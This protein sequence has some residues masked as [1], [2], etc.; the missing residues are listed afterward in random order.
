M[1]SVFVSYRRADSSD[2]TG[3]I[4]DHLKAEFGEEQLFKDVEAIPLGHDFRIVI[5]Q[6]VGQCKVLIAI[7]GNDWLNAA[8]ATGKR[9]ID[10]PNDYV[11]FEI[12]TALERGIP[13]I[14]VLV[15]GASIPAET[16]LPPALHQL[17]FRNAVPVRVDPDFHHDINRLLTELNRQVGGL[18][19]V[20]AHIR[21]ILSGKKRTWAAVTIVA[22][23]TFVLAAIV[24]WPIEAV[25]ENEFDVMD[26]YV[27]KVSSFPSKESAQEFLHK[28]L[29]EYGEIKHSTFARKNTWE[30]DTLVVRDPDAAG[31]YLV[32]ID[33]F[34]GRQNDENV[35]MEL[36]KIRQY[37]SKNVA[38]NPLGRDLSQAISYDYSARLWQCRYGNIDTSIRVP[39]NPNDP[40]ERRRFDEK[41]E[42]IRNGRCFHRAWIT[43]AILL[44]GS[45]GGSSLVVGHW[46][47]RRRNAI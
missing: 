41:V 35:K 22:I 21:R 9:R 47:A 24:N 46:Y 39:D 31:R 30:E 36:D 16:E 33:T 4:F 34:Y 10:D 37:A 7:I 6:A 3:R 13:V 14:P 38:A 18:S 15:E 43:A 44:G 8:D 17:A 28:F 12:A 45:L 1:R 20:T 11:R 19:G 23:I 26:E 42:R 40:D 27:I 32:V 25:T 29:K 5:S 2:I